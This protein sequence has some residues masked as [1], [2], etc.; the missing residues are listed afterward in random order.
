MI[1]DI[2]NALREMLQGAFA[3]NGSPRKRGEVDIVFDQPKRE[4]SARVSKPTLN[5]FLYDIR[6]NTEL[7]A[8]EQ[9]LREQ[10][11]NDRIRLR[12]SPV[13][14]DL[15]Y[16]VTGWAKEVQDEHRLLS[17]ALNTFLRNPVIPDELL[18]DELKLPM[19]PV[20]LTVAQ[21]KATSD[22]SDLW[23]T[24]DNEIRAGLRLVVTIA[25]EP[26]EPELVWPVRTAEIDIV[27]T[28]SADAIAATPKGKRPQPTLDKKF[29]FIGGKITSQ[30]HSPAVLKMYLVGGTKKESAA[31]GGAGEEGEAGGR[32]IQLQP[33]PGGAQFSISQLT[34]GEYLLNVLANERLLKRQKILVPSESYDF[35][36]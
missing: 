4:W 34:E 20:R 32:E 36:V 21:G 8:S 1:P 29:F 15:C 35:E 2:D 31:R 3:P 14:M 24:L 19:L 6:E 22:L 28:P 5:L 33:I 23:S 17:A 25:L 12:H 27:Q 9:P 18:P 16:L 13:R 26:I 11:E 10:A 30:K 7:R